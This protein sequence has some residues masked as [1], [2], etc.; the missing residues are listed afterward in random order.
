MRTRGSG[1]PE[2]EYGLVCPVGLAKTVVWAASPTDGP[3]YRFLPDSVGKDSFSS[4]D[5]VN[6]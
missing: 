2:G 4:K 3:P 5:D 6:V 1:W